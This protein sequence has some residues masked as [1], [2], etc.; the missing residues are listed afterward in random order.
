MSFIELNENE[1]D[2]PLFFTKI[3]NTSLRNELL[4]AIRNHWTHDSTA[5]EGNT[6]TL[7]E[8]DFVLSEGVTIAGKPLSHHQEVYGHAKAIDL[9]YGL[10]NKA[11]IEQS[12]VFL[13]HQAILSER[14]YDIYHPVG[15]WKIEPNY[16]FYA[17]DDKRVEHEYPHPEVVPVLMD[18]W[19]TRANGWVERIKWPKDA[20]QSYSDLHARFIAVHPFVDGNGRMARLLANIPL[21]KNG[22]PPI[23]IPSQERL[24]YLNAVAE[25]TSP[26]GDVSLE[27]NLDR[28]IDADAVNR[29]SVLCE[30]WWQPILDLVDRTTEK[31]AKLRSKS[32]APPGAG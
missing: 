9:V 20:V 5:I 1:R 31:D 11:R 28:V 19:L 7:G 18:Q 30:R 27:K 15:K 16:T 25:I 13:L 29:F 12:D 23:N 3:Y 32:S 17:R 22:F 4:R 26:C 6:L 2:M 24:N 8:T 14:I 10:L 21:L